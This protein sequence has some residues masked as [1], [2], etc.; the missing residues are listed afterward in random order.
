MKKS[1]EMHFFF[2]VEYINSPVVISSLCRYIN[3]ILKY[4]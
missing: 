2:V 4:I 3:A 1:G